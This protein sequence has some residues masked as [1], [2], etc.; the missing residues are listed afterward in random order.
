MPEQVSYVK[1]A[2]KEPL[3]IWALVICVA[4]SV[5][6]ATAASDFG[7]LAWLAY[8]MPLVL[9]GAGEVLYLSTLPNTAQYRRTVDERMRRKQLAGMDRNRRG[10]SN[11]FGSP[12]HEAVVDLYWL[13]NP[14]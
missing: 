10:V 13:Q 6:A 12:E 3:N 8:W 4:L 1:E 9:G 14:S 11:P 5:F 2:F 7:V